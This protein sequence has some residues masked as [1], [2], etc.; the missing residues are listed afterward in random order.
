[1][2]GALATDGAR[3]IAPP[4]LVSSRILAEAVIVSVELNAPVVP[5]IAPPEYPPPVIAPVT[6][7]VPGMV[8]APVADIPSFSVP[9]IDNDNVVPISVRGA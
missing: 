8:T 9:L 2:L 6:P 5:L 3:K 4:G 1:M 7:R